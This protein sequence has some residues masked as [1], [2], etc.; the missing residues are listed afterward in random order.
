MSSH[1]TG[2][3]LLSRDTLA[4]TT[5]KIAALP[6]APGDVWEYNATAD[7]PGRIIEVASGIE[8]PP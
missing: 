3:P 1:V 4:K 6:L 2:R 8:L 5:A 7:V